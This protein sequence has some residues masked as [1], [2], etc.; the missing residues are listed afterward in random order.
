MA[1]VGLGGLA[2]EGAGA[3]A[4]E[5]AAEAL[6]WILGAIEEGAF[7][8]AGALASLFAFVLTL[9]GQPRGPAVRRFIR[10]T[11]PGQQ[12]FQLQKKREEGV[13]VFYSGA[14]DPPL[15]EAEILSN[16]RPGSG[17]AVRT[18]EEITALGLIV[19]QTPGAEALAPRLQAA[20]FEIRPGPGMSR[21]DF[22]AAL[23]VLSLN[24]GNE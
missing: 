15:T 12:A 9:P 20:H 2:A 6:P 11:S 3:A 14:V 17:V 10:V 22:K 21:D 7:W 16:F 24:I 4:L 19:V 23:K 18:F 1:A 8:T 5:G 13:S